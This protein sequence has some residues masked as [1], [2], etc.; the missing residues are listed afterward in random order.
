MKISRKKFKT[1]SQRQW[2]RRR[3]WPLTFKGAG[4]KRAWRLWAALPLDE[5]FV[6][7]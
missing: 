1:L 5:Q 7:M 3:Q 6:E 4:R 2:D